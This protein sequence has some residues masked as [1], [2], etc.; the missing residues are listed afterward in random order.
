MA[1]PRPKYPIIDEHTRELI[2]D[3][4]VRQHSRY[5]G[6]HTTTQRADNLILPNL[7]TNLLHGRVNI[8][9]HRP[10]RSAPTDV[11]HEIL[12]NRGALRRVRHFGMKL[13]AIDPAFPVVPPHGGDRRIVRMRDRPKPRRHAF[14]PITV[15]HPDNGRTTL[16][17]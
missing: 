5:G 1:L 2:A 3:S 15:R 16:A 9:P 14:D 8:R 17:D 13:Q 4:T 7:M 6:V 10:R 12:Q 11:V